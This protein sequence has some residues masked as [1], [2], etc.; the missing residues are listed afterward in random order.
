MKAYL[1]K[2]NILVTLYTLEVFKSA[3]FGIPFKGPKHLR[4]PY[5]GDIARFL[6]HL[7]CCSTVSRNTRKKAR[8]KGDKDWTYSV[9]L[10]AE[11]LGKPELPRVFKQP[12]DLPHTRALE[13]IE[14]A[15]LVK[16]IKHIPESKCREFA[17]SKKFLHNLFTRD[18]AKYLRRTDR[19]SHL[20]NIF[21]KRKTYSFDELI[22]QAISRG[23]TVKHQW[24]K[25]DI[26]NEPFRNLLKA[27]W[28]N[29]EP[30]HIN[31]DALRQYVDTHHSTKNVM[32]YR[33][34]LSHLAEVGVDLISDTPLVVAYRQSYKSAKIGGRSFEVGTG[35]QSLPSAMKWACLAKGYNYDIKGCQLEILR[36]E[37]QSIGVSDSNLQLLDTEVI[38]K[39]LKVE[40][41]LVK[42][43]RYASVFN[44]GYVSFSCKSATVRLL[45]KAFGPSK[46][47][48]ILLRWREHLEPLKHDLARLLDH[49]EATARTNR[50][51]KCVTN[52]VGQTFNCT[53]KC[54]AT[55]KSWRSDVMRRKLLAHMLQGLES[56]AVYDF[57][58]EHPGLVCALEHDG[59]I[60]YTKI[61]QGDWQHPFLTI[62]LKNKAIHQ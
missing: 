4:R 38:C 22:G 58:R 1:T 2:N 62:V 59:F 55:G 23:C 21:N 48:R 52:A 57:V 16:I 37:L 13:L 50:Y 25:R 33:S 51:G 18:R 44:S 56:R 24:S 35:F 40:E 8:F 10:P 27:V 6:E 14:E 53:Y 11:T 31:L 39:V 3:L 32:F 49:Y 42:Q 54:V 20:T 45:R 47:K 43:F 34:F 60:S 41:A 5:Y 61:D 15:G 17:V 46:A 7:I 29:I 9:P 19:I 36:C 28:G 26:P 12:K 30:L